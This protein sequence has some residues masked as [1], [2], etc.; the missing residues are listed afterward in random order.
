MGYSSDKKG[1]HSVFGI[2]ANRTELEKVVDVLKRDG[3][4]NSDI[5]VLMQN[6]G[7][8]RDF[9][10]EKHTKAPEGTAAGAATGL[11]GGG[12]LGWL[13]GAGALAIPGIGPFVAAGPIMAAVAGAGIGGAVGGIAGGLIGLGIPEYEAKRYESFVKNGGILI[14]VH[15]DDSEWSS[16]AKDILERGGA[17][18][19]SVVGEQGERSKY[20][21]SN[22][23][24]NLDRNISG[25]DMY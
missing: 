4:R 18:E 23:D 17:S 7:E 22:K 1:S 24:V 15:V 20:F 8:T 14:S 9:A 6:K 25:R 5:S 10:Y 12:I 21:S 13:A 2:F 11:L 16:K 19:V 3:F